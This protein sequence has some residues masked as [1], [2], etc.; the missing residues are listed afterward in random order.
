[1][2]AEVFEKL[3]KRIVTSL[4]DIVILSMLRNRSSLSGYDIIVSVHNEFSFL[5][6]SG[7]IYSVLYSLERESLIEGKWNQ[8][9]R[10]YTLTRKGE[11]NIKL[12]LQSS[13]KILETIKEIFDG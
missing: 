7:T 2:K 8:R 4:M 11:E 9:K 12:L 1:L 6:N 13:E 3:R 10:V 5:M